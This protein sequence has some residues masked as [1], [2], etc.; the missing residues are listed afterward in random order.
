MHKKFLPAAALL[1]FLAVAIGA[2]GSHALKSLLDEQQM[3]V[4]QTAAATIF[5]HALGLGLVSILAK[6]EG[7][8][9]WLAWAG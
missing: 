7:G 8:S 1:A 3:A 4:Y 5:F 9:R 2:F 6:A